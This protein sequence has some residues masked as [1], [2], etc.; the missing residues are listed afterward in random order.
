M[1]RLKK[2]DQVAYI[3]FASVYQSFKDAADFA[4]ELGKLKRKK[5][6]K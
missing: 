3:R 4:A 5:L 2:V 6:K 1:K